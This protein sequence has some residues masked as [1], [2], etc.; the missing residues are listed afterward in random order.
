MDDDLELF[1]ASW[2]A[3]VNENQMSLRSN[4]HEQS[5]QNDAVNAYIN[6]STH[7]REGNYHAAMT[8]YRRGRT[9]YL[10]HCS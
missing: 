8:E 3:E 7:E 6:A 9:L 4:V 1:R 2:I 10:L 5:S